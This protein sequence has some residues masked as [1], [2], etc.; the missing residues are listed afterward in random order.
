M[1]TPPEQPKA[2]AAAAPVSQKKKKGAPYEDLTFKSIYGASH[3]LLLKSLKN[4]CH[5]VFFFLTFLR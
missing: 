1:G 3:S 2:S 4:T 5:I